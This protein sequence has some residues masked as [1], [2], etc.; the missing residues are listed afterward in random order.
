MRRAGVAERRLQLATNWE[1]GIVDDSRRQRR[2]LAQPDGTRAAYTMKRSGQSGTGF[3][4]DMILG[5][6]V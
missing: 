1:A 3:R 4:I 5:D 2:H 6:D